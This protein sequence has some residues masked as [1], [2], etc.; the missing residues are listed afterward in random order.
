MTHRPVICVVQYSSNLIVSAVHLTEP[1]PCL[2][3]LITSIKSDDYGEGRGTAALMEGIR[4][5]PALCPLPP[6][7]HCLASAGFHPLRE[8]LM[9]MYMRVPVH[10]NDTA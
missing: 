7:K 2:V 10:M 8:P 3:Y 4:R 9:C 1:W 5:Q 6:R